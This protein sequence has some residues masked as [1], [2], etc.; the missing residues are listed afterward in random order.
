M[1]I[2][3]STCQHS[4]A[5]QACL[6]TSVDIGSVSGATTLDVE[7]AAPRNFVVGRP[8]HMEHAS[9]LNAGLL[10]GDAQCVFNS[11]KKIRFRVINAT[12]GALDPGAQVFKF[13]QQ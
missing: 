3:K 5:I 13:W 8:V 2:P 9:A 7:V 4:Q 11:G 1:A 6:E 10:I 12:A